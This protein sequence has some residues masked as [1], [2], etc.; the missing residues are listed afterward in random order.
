MKKSIKDFEK[1]TFFYL[2]IIFACI[3]LLFI[4]TISI[5]YL[6]QSKLSIFNLITITFS[7]IFFSFLFYRYIKSITF[8]ILFSILIML[9]LCLA[10][11]LPLLSFFLIIFLIFAFIKAKQILFPKIL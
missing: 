3:A 11:K 7:I 5:F 9:T 4:F 2:F 6:S 1:E 10:N 8:Y